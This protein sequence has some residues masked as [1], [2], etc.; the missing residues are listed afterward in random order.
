MNENE[1]ADLWDEGHAA[2]DEHG[3]GECHCRNPYR[4]YPCLEPG[5]IKTVEHPRDRHIND[6][7]K[8]WWGI[9]GFHEGVSA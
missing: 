8:R 1:K 4:K 7:G 5:C 6:A 3:P 2:T 9:G